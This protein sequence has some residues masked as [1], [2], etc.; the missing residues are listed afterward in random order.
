VSEFVD[1]YDDLLNFFIPLR[2]RGLLEEPCE[3]RN[4]PETIELAEAR[5]ETAA[6]DEKL[7]AL[8]LR[9]ADLQ[10]KVGE[11][12]Y[13]DKI[14]HELHDE[15]Q[16]YKAGLREE[17]VKPLLKTIIRE[18]DRA[19]QQYD[20]YSHKFK[21]EP[22]SELCEKLLKEFNM[23][24]FGLLDILD[25][26]NVEPFKANEGDAFLP[27]EYRAITTVET[28]DASKGGKIER[29]LKCGFRNTES[30]KLIRQ[31]EVTIYK[32]NINKEI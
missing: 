15:L 23:I 24:S 11:F 10:E 21:E 3:N 25:D 18:Y 8:D 30:G 19:I 7:E 29:C 27:R 26:Y 13:K 20:F 12:T 2:K 4:D 32:M 28:N 22:Q 5:P 1:R 31:A 16:S 14:N 6:I 17:F 9:L